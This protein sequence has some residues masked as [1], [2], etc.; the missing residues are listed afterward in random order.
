MLFILGARPIEQTQE[1]MMIAQKSITT[2]NMAQYTEAVV[3]EAMRL[4]S[5]K[6][7]AHCWVCEVC[8]MPHTGTAP[9]HCDSCG[10]AIS[11]AQRFDPIPEFN[12][13]W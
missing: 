10:V 8:G 7:T 13:R 1:T 3:Q 2:H 6:P 9:E 5:P 4:L 11:P 12:S